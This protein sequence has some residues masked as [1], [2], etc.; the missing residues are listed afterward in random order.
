MYQSSVT[1]FFLSIIGSTK[2]SVASSFVYAHNWDYG[3]MVAHY[4]PSGE[5]AHHR[6]FAN[7]RQLAIVTT[8]LG[9][10]LGF[11][12]MDLANGISDE[13]VILPTFNTVVTGG[14]TVLNSPAAPE[15]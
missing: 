5:A 8:P 15:P 14:L 2:V 4:T 10:E 1:G 12:G 6:M 11:K 3:S 9:M 13:G 7:I